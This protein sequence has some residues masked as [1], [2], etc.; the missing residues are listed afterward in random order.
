M[1]RADPRVKVIALIV[2]S[3]LSFL[4]ENVAEAAFMAAVLALSYLVARVSPRAFGKT[5]RPFLPLFVISLVVNLLAVRGGQ[6]LWE[7][8][9]LVIT[10]QGVAFGVFATYRAIVALGFGALLVATTSPVALADA[11]EK[12]LAPLRLLGI[13][14]VDVAMILSIA[15]R[16]IPLLS[17]EAN[18]VLRAQKARGVQG[19]ERGLV[20]R[21]KSYA[22]LIVPLLA[23]SLRHAERLAVAMEARCYAAP[24]TRTH[25]APLRLA[26]CAIAAF[27]LLALLVAAFIALRV[28]VP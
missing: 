10:G 17:D 1:A 27:A 15:L 14:V 24:V 19:H 13:S 9:P 11:L 22:S 2:C 26:P 3:V 6:V 18:Q 4:V 25:L 20:G 28:F 16:A 8:G 23:N 5:V 12:L 7:L 21:I